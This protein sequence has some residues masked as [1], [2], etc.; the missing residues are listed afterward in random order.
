MKKLGIALISVII[1][2]GSIYFL[3]D[4]SLMPVNK[5]AVQMIEFMV[6]PQDIPIYTISNRERIEEI[7]SNINKLEKTKTNDTPNQ[8]GD[9]YLIALKFKDGEQLLFEMADDVFFIGQE[10]YTADT[11]ELRALLAQT[12]YDRHGTIE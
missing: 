11:S 9:Y 2:C 12:Y 4:R 3:S 10:N 5:D 7:V 6:Y 1:L 8:M